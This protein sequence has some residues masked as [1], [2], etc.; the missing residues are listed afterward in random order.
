MP[1]FPAISSFSL[2]TIT[3]P[4]FY[5][6]FKHQHPLFPSYSQKMA[7]SLPSKEL[8]L[9]GGGRGG[10][11]AT[12]I[13][14][15]NCLIFQTPTSKSAS[16]PMVPACPPSFLQQD[17]R[18][19]SRHQSDSL[20][21]C[22]TSHAPPTFSETLSII[23]AFLLYFFLLTIQILLLSNFFPRGFSNNSSLSHWQH[24]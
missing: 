16:T 19:L 18:Q 24:K 11:G 23:H 21:A 6:L 20:L 17:R 12:S 2:S 22:S 7:W 15:S 10:G 1:H 14:R 3:N 13:S 8:P 5:A 4:D 9:K